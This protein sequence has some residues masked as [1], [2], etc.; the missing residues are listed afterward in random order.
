MKKKSITTT[1]VHYLGW[2]ALIAHL[3]AASTVFSMTEPIHEFHR[4]AMYN[5]TANLKRLLA[6]NIDV[7]AT[8]R[9]RK[10]ALHKAAR[11]DRRETMSLLKKYGANLDIQDNEGNTPLH[12]AA[13]NCNEY[14]MNYLVWLGARTNIRNEQGQ[15]ADELLTEACRRPSPIPV[16]PDPETQLFTAAQTGDVAKVRN[17]LEQNISA[18][19]TDVSQHNNTPLHVAKN[20]EVVNVLL[21]YGADLEARNELGYTPLNW[22][23]NDITRSDAALALLA[24]NAIPNVAA[25]H[26]YGEMQTPLITAIR[27]RDTRLVDALLKKGFKLILT[28]EAL[29]NAAEAEKNNE[30]IKLLVHAKLDVNGRNH[31]QETALHTAARLNYLFNLVELLA[32]GANPNLQDVD[33]KTPLH[34]AVERDYPR[35][36]KALLLPQWQTHTNVN[37]VDRLGNT[38]LHLTKNPAIAQL[39]LDAGANPFARAGKNRQTPLE[40]IRYK[41]D[42]EQHRDPDA[43][44]AK[45]V[46]ILEQAMRKKLFTIDEAPAVPTRPMPVPKNHLHNAINTGHVELVT[47]LLNIQPTLLESRDH[48]GRT[49]LHVAAAGGHTAIVEALLTAGADAMVVDNN[50]QTPLHM[51][52]NAPIVRILLAK[53]VDIDATDAQAK[54]PMQTLNTPEARSMLLQAKIE[55]QRAQGALRMRVQ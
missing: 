30:V 18:N 17:L 10:T 52:S 11:L 8:D 36:I 14:A 6:A 4:Y 19:I 49:P 2:S 16:E 15:T 5:D 45:M 27:N 37:V 55:R 40:K 22:A 28:P 32:Q 21:K 47:E 39:L 24:A 20:A 44:Y 46:K 12:I 26:G 43:R 33:G 48:N 54:S 53:G 31:R 41:L 38:P 3:A 9:N 35:I 34:I 1:I 7:N 50:L 42:E 51:A 25:I 29:H 23:A 13:S